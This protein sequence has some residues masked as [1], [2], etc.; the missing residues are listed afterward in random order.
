[1]RTID[2]QV[3]VSTLTSGGSFVILDELPIAPGCVVTWASMNAHNTVD[4][5]FDANVILAFADVVTTP[6]VTFP[7]EPLTG[8]TL[9]NGVPGA[10]VAPGAT[11]V[12]GTINGGQY[13]STY[14]ATPFPVIVPQGG[15]ANTT[16]PIYAVL[17]VIQ[18][19]T[20][21]DVPPVVTVKIQISC[22]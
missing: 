14:A 4:A 19:V 3:D 18:A 2:V 11:P 8:G 13:N 21:G 1:M 22:P 17:Q 7:D 12:P 9:V 5:S 6:G 15:L 16:Q 10:P 20:P